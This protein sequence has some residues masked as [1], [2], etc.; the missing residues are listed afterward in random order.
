MINSIFMSSIINVVTLFASAGGGGSSSDSDGGGGL[1]ML[2][3]MITYIP[4]SKWG[5]IYR[6]KRELDHND[7]EFKAK[8]TMV[9]ICAGLLSL[10]AFILGGIIDSSFE[11]S[12]YIGFVYV[13][14]PLVLGSI[15]GSGQGLYSWFNK[16][17][18]NKL[19]QANLAQSATKDAIWNESYLKN[20][21]TAVYRQFQQDWSNFDLKR[22]SAY[23]TP[24]YYKHMVLMLTVMKGMN[25]RNIT[26]VKSIE[27]VEIMSMN[28]YDDDNNDTFVA[29]F[30]TELN[31]QLIDIRDN[32]LIYQ[33]NTSD[34]A[35]ENWRFKRKGN[36]WLL[37]GIN[38]LT[39]DVTTRERK[40]QHFAESAGGYYSL[41]QGRLLIPE[42]GQ[43]F[44][45]GSF[46]YSDINNHMI[47]E[48]AD[49]NHLTSDAIL[50]QIYT[51]SER[52]AN[53]GSPIYLVGQITV[54]KYYE[55][56]VVQRRHGKSK[57][58]I[59]GLQEI[60]LEWREFNDKFQVFATTAEQVTSFELLNPQM[61]EWLE[62]TPFEINLEVVDN[63]I[64][65][66]AP[67][68]KADNMGVDEYRTMLDIL[69]ASYRELKM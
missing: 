9:W 17:K 48:L 33:W 30:S 19:I 13:A 31:D 36:T 60:S 61:M 52:P 3:A 12:G 35:A 8:A 50:Y 27:A 14:L 16:I 46:A 32:R 4:M 62:A 65:F 53:D 11:D 68:A 10:L 6:K 54:P 69:Q 51:Y 18:P 63:N 28:D 56:I 43:L 34:E 59:K 7:I 67:M 22:M 1:L 57:V 58:K 37:D 49:S 55:D 45:G 41:D 23:L 25:R 42:R 64:Y 15:M 66:Y 20:G 21:A 29:G 44:G 26:T 24:H 2:I 39:E 47:G 38:P 40:I 5:K